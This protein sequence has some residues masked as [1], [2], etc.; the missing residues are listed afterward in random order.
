M[1]LAIIRKV[2]FFQNCICKLNIF[3]SL[4]WG[5]ECF[6]CYSI[7][8]AVECYHFN[9]GQSQSMPSPQVLNVY[10]MIHQSA[11]SGKHSSI[12]G[13]WTVCGWRDFNMLIETFRKNCLYFVQ[14]CSEFS[15]GGIKYNH[16]V[17]IKSTCSLKKKMPRKS[18]WNSTHL[19]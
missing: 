17:F 8:A 14:V 5:T 1:Y 2:F 16:N 10:Q 9:G 4:F 6:R 15:G 18:G 13:G 3:I 19:K 12:N 7:S 11:I